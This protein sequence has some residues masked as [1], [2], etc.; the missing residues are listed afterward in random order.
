MAEKLEK[1]N[2][3][4]VDQLAMLRVRILDM[5][6]MDLDRHEDQWSWG[7][8]D[9]GKGKTFYP[10]AKDRDQA[11]YINQ[12]LLP[13]FVKGVPWYHNWKASS[14]RPRAL[15]VSILPPVTLTVS[16]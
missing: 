2:D 15:P 6:V 14:P 13:W 8:W 5:F 7:A 4:D 9:N 16:S 12:G 10:V 11:F 1:D 3:N